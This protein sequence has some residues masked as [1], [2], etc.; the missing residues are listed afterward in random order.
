MKLFG[1]IKELVAAV[2][3]KDGKEVT[4]TVGSQTGAAVN[5]TFQLPAVNAASDF[6]KTVAISGDIVNA[7]ISNTA[8][9]TDD[10][11]ATISTAGKVSGNAITSGAIGGSTSINTTGAITTSGILTPSNQILM[12]GPNAFIRDYASGY[13]TAHV[14]NTLYEIGRMT[15]TSTAQHVT[16]VGELRASSGSVVSSSRFVMQI[17]WDT[18][19]SK[20]F[21]FQEEI[22]KS[23]TATVNVKLYHDTASGL[24]IIGYQGNSAFQS[25]GWSLKIQ[26]R[27]SYNYF[28]QVSTL[29]TLSTAGL[30]EVTPTQTFIQERTANQAIS[31]NSTIDALKVTQA[32]TGNAILV[33][34]QVSDTSPFVVK[35]DGSVGIGTSTPTTALDVN[36]TV[37]ATSFSGPLTGNVTGNVS[38]SAA[39][40]T[41]SLSG[42]V[43]GTQSA[44]IVAS[45]VID[46][47]NISDTAGIVDTKLA[48]ISTP[49]KVD[50]TATTATSSNIVST[51]VARDA[52]GNFNAGAVTLTGDIG[53]NGGDITTTATTFNLIN[54]TATTVN[55]AGAATTLNV[56]GTTA[57]STSN[58]AGGATIASSTKTVN[59]GTGG[60]SGSTTNVNIGSSV[61]GALN[62]VTFNGTNA[63]KLPSGTAAQ[64]P[65]QAGQPA[66]VNG[67]IRYNTS[68]ST[69]EGYASNAWSP[70][71]SGGTT[72]KFTQASPV[73]AIGDVVYLNGSVYTKAIA[74]AANTS[75]IVGVISR[76]PTTLGA[77]TYE[78]TLSGE[79]SGF[80][81]LTTGEV[82]FLSPT[83]AGGVT[84]TEPSTIGQVSVPVGIASSATSLYVAP[85]RGVVIGGT[86]ARTQIS[87]TA[88]TTAQTIYT[89]P[90]G[91]D[92]GELT[93]WVYLDA[94]A[95]KKFY[96]SAPF[97]KNGAG[98]DWNISPSYVGDT[99]P[100]GFGITMTSA[101]LIQLT[102]NPLPTG[103]VSG[104]INYALNAPAVGATFPLAVDASTIT[105]G[106]IDAA[107]LPQV[108]SSSQGAFP[109]LTS[110][111]DN[112][113]AT[114]LG[115]KQYLHGTTYNGGNAPTVTSSQA[116]ASIARGTFV[117]YQTQDGAWRLK[118][119][120]GFTY[121]LTSVASSSV[122]VN[123][124]NAKNISNF[125]QAVS[126]FL[127]SSA[128]PN[129]TVA[130]ASPN[131]NTITITSN[132]ANTSNTI[133]VSG[134]I[135][136]NAKPTW[137]Y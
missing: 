127:N 23:N 46:N 35:S 107:R 53:V 65:G 115:L 134:D 58:F 93:G 48:T 41:G 76:D 29:T 130:Y 2:F 133:A 19:T 90:A 103:F 38:G 113:T 34:D 88:V 109:S 100:T 124:I 92:A 74:T 55:T 14:A 17:R 28:T 98:T 60:V 114:Q 97:A 50:N 83:T 128:A 84:V 59:V 77:N 68:S 36:G 56:G 78:V 79:V 3:R 108:S 43:T 86:N 16:V 27:A 119:N 30:T 33:E 63:I 57:T 47:D 62:T 52:S 25:A 73:L 117:P 51:I 132:A 13:N 126:V 7:D 75:E 104:Y 94:T 10:K 91:L 9:I 96:V 70:I 89:A 49:G 129:L 85:K 5:R 95:D 112:A 125:N 102:M 121:T 15:A 45:G 6:T 20:T 123:G 137:A 122:S 32:G 54:T 4:F 135:E 21:S 136:L 8:N 101:G 40:F 24:V 120:I 42:E 72:D 37:T 31:V 1:S 81:G 64:Q 44:T 39:S 116:G 22:L 66:A 105:A 82:Y 131:S 12:G 118:F 111:L 71:G 99:P 11:L 26:E 67:M 106:T 69:F 61:S 87:L 18:I 80:T 110:S